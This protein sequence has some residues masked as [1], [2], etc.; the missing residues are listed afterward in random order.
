[1]NDDFNPQPKGEESWKQRHER[2]V[3]EDT[4]K[5]KKAWAKYKDR[6]PIEDDKEGP[7]R[8]VTFFDR[9]VDAPK[10]HRVHTT[11]FRFYEDGTMY[12]TK[13]VEK[14]QKFLVVN[15]PLAGQRIQ[16]NNQDYVLFNR[17]GYDWK[18]K[19]PKCVLVHRSSLVET[20]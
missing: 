8:R 3:R 13:S 6:K 1:M 4:E 18:N 19:T 12:V 7:G 5:A 11:S 20:K 16:D 17:N 15:G 2:Q 10:E 14:R 9:I